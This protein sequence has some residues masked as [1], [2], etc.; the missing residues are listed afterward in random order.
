M[1][2]ELFWSVGSWF[3]RQLVKG[4]ADALDKVGTL[5]CV[6]GGVG[7]TASYAMDNTLSAGYYASADV[8]GDA[9]VN[10]TVA[11]FN[12]QTT[13][14][15]PFTYNGDKSEG[16]SFKLSDYV[17]A[18]AVRVICVV[19]VASG[20]AAR[21]VSAGLNKWQQ[22]RDDSRRNQEAYQIELPRASVKE[23]LFL[24]ASS[25][26]HSMCI[27]LIG[28]TI[29]NSLLYSSHFI[30]GSYEYTYPSNGTVLA[31]STY[32]SGPLKTLLTP[33]DV[34]FVEDVV[35]YVSFLKLNVTVIEAVNALTNITANY[36]GGILIESHNT[37]TPSI[38][39]PAVAG[40][41]SY[42]LGNFFAEKNTNLRMQRHDE[43]RNNQY[44][45][46]IT[47]D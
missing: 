34:Q 1:N 36:G 14:N 28:N 42:V 31:N 15:I 37:S 13:K 45:P 5:A 41:T 24:G 4:T 46:L 19:A 8:N 32:Y 29:A 12:Y 27:V 35:A 9:Y 22:G 10:I 40:A 7:Y 2:A 43:A 33:A 39:L 38:A 23:Y 17:T 30:G 16:T 6:A 47:G 21:L 3:L 44:L 11:Q 20:T 26:T 25:V 18:E